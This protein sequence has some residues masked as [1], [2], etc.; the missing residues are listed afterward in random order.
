VGFA[1]FADRLNYGR[2]GARL[3][4]ALL[5]GLGVWLDGRLLSRHERCRGERRVIEIAIAADL[6]D[7]SR[8]CI[9]DLQVFLN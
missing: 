7:P 5:F 2:H 8:G 9:N 3:K 1:P 6:Q 4:F